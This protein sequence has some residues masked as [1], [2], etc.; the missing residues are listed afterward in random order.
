[1]KTAEPKKDLFKKNN[2]F[3]KLKYKVEWVEYL[4]PHTLQAPLKASRGL[5]AS[6]NY[7]KITFTYKSI[8]QEP[9]YGD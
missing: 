4:P 3:I 7:R 8:I 6:F 2:S 5:A 1:M 9:N